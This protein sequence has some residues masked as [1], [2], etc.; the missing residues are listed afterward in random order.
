MVCLYNVVV[1]LDDLM[2]AVVNMVLLNVSILINNGI[3]S[4]VGLLNGRHMFY[5]SRAQYSGIWTFSLNN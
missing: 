3:R 4:L 2:F 1:S 5:L